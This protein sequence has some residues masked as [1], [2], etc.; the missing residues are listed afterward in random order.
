[1]MQR[2]GASAAPRASEVVVIG[3]GIAGVATAYYL[4]RAG[5]PVTLCE[6]GRIA[7]EQ[8]SRNWGWIRKQGRD[9]RELPAIILALRLWEEIAASL[10]E[11]I[12][13][14][15][16]GVAYLAESEAE[17]ARHAAWLPH[18]QAHQLDTRLL[19]PA[20]TDALLGQDGRRFKGALF[21]PSDARAEPGRAV[22][23]LARAAAALGASMHE[24]C[25]VR[26][27]ETS[28]GKVAGVVTEHGRLACQ[29]VVLAGGAWS[30][31]FLRHLG[32]EL[33]QLKVK[34][35]VQRTTPGPLISESAVGATRAAFRRRQDGGY[36]IARS[37]AVTFDIT[38]AA[39][40]HWQAFLPALRERWG[41]IKLRLGRSFVDELTT[42]ASWSADRA[43]PFE[44]TRVLDPAPD[45]AVLD[46]VM[47]D[48]ALLF[49]QL[50]EVRPVERWAGMIDVTPDEI[51]VLGPVDELPGLFVATGFSGHGFGIGPAA[52]YLIAE[53]ATGRR[54]LLDLRPFRFA[55]FREGDV[56]RL[57]EA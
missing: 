37:G 17:L 55:R 20:E 45:H 15:R 35:S 54:P 51:P 3:G 24:S 13:W 8:S 42:S 46:Q 56:T 36:T 6:K 29:A 53:L 39:L 31:L 23:A 26:A 49:P 5:V 48:A 7:G 50:R 27:L 4:A 21:T 16:G 9:P 52:G 33:P 25:A 14:T 41:E 11:D 32:I 19:S 47:R 30:A 40:R 18:A 12:G 28:A 2:P 22:P 10:A 1:M 43:T 44:R 38:P 57:P 34:A